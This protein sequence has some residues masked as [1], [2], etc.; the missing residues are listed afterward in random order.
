MPTDTPRP[1][2]TVIPFPAPAG[3]NSGSDPRRAKPAVDP[4]PTAHCAIAT[5]N[6]WYHEAAL[7]DAEPARKG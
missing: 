3:S 7:R 5:G 4:K 1:S 6:G 2:A